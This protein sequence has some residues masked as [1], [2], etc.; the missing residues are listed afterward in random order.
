MSNYHRPVPV[1]DDIH[2]F[3]ELLDIIDCPAN[4]TDYNIPQVDPK[5]AEPTQ[6]VVELPKSQLAPATPPPQESIEEEPE[7]KTEQQSSKQDGIDII[8][9]EE[10]LSAEIYE[11]KQC[12]NNYSGIEMEEYNKI[13][14]HDTE[15]EH[16]TVLTET[17][18]PIPNSNALI[19]KYPGIEFD[20]EQANEESM[21]RP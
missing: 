6:S 19:T 5:P 11:N 3:C 13:G 1:D 16:S 7:L 12:I 4:T 14:N 18:I 2:Q 9:F 21:K 8:P 10:S 20:V 15:M 17:S